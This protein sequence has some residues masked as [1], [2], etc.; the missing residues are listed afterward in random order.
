MLQA[1]TSNRLA[2]SFFPQ[3]YTFGRA[4]HA[5][6]MTAKK[7]SPSA[8]RNKYPIWE[9]LESNVL[10][11]LTSHTL[12]VVEIAAGAGGQFKIASYCLF[13]KG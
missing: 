7:E 13:V 12:R 11:T 8:D 1:F 4:V 10:P 9:I 6:N 3:R 5:T 2:T